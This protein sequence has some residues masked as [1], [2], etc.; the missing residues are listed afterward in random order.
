VPVAVTEHVVVARQCP[1]CQ[2]PVVPVVDL[3]GVVDGP[4]RLGTHL[5]SLITTLREVGR[6]PVRTVQWYLQTVH[7]LHLSVGALVDASRR[8]AAHGAA[9]VAQ[10]REQIRGSPVVHADETGWREN[11]G[12]GYVWTFCTPTLRYF[13]RRDRSKAVVDE[14]LGETF[15]GVLGCD[16]YAAYHHY[17]GLKQRCWAHLLRDIHDLTTLYPQDRGLQRWARRIKAL[18]KR[19]VAWRSSDARLR[20]QA[21]QRYERALAALC[22]PFVEDPLAVQRRL[23][24]RIV[25]HLSELLVFVAHP[26]AEA[27]NNRAERSLRPLV[28]SRKVSGGTRSAQG[29]ETKMTL[30]SLFGTWHAQ[31]RDPFAACHQLLVASQL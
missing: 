7:Q 12:N 5:I 28:T 14:V 15:A 3:G 11:G 1:V 8:V 2:V 24:R 27:D 16:F 29:T 10:I 13:V 31:G 30:A 21:Q 23:C 4:Q 25:R 18:F 26:E 20:G 9:A 22:T 19:A 17:P 6:L